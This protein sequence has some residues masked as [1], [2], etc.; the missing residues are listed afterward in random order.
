ME[1]SS[2]EDSSFKANLDASNLSVRSNGFHQN[3]NLVKQHILEIRKISS[4]GNIGEA[5]NAEV[6][7]ETDKNLERVTSSLSNDE[8]NSE[9]WLPPEPEDWEDDVIGRVASYDDDDDEC[10]DDVTWARPSSLSSVEEE[11]SGSYK[12]K[13]EKLNAMNS[14]KN[15]KFMALVSQLVKSVGVESCGDRS[16]DWVE[17]VTSLS[18]EAAVFVK[19]NTHEG[20][21]MDPDGYVKIKCIATGS[22]SQ[23]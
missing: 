3:S 21:A 2:L 22:R 23:R 8:G 9:F 13:E 6:L 4:F 19:P 7:Q 1:E 15:G 11:V 16:E 10:G 17:I 14:I 20:K 12:F 18:W 5:E